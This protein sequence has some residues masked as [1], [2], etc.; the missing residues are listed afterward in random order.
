MNIKRSLFISIFILFAVT[1]YSSNRLLIEAAK[2]GNLKKIKIELNKGVDINKPYQN[3]TVL[4]W[5]SAKNHIHVV[6]YLIKKGADV[7]K[8]CKSSNAL[9]W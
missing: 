2:T 8:M 1:S 9:M 5:A 7:N 4:M 6:R 3:A